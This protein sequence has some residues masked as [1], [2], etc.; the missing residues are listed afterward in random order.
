MQV[1]RAETHP[2]DTEML[3]RCVSLH[4]Y[5]MLAGLVRDHEITL[6]HLA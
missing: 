6:L 4:H 1:F 2:G 3:P 5:M